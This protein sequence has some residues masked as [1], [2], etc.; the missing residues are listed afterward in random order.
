M[1]A[2]ALKFGYVESNNTSWLVYLS[3]GLYRYKTPSSN[4]EALHSLAEYLYQKFICD[5]KYRIDLHNKYQSH[6]AKCCRI[7]WSDEW[8]R[9][10]YE[11]PQLKNCPT[12]NASYSLADPKF[13][14]DR[15]I[16]FLIGIS[17]SDCDR[18]G[19]HDGVDNPF[20]WD[21]WSFD[22]SLDKKDI[23]VIPERAECFLL[24]A[25]KEIHPELF[26]ESD[27]E[28]DDYYTSFYLK[29]YQELCEG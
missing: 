17:I 6:M 22:F 2:I 29:P 19:E 11:M 16:E 7:T 9:G 21:P 14:E 1:K 5:D 27:S 28:Y 10:N 20:G 18:Y 24:M 3:E 8:H 23:I 12:C 25:L 15:W 13:D 4:K 26:D